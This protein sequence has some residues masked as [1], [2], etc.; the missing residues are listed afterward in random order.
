MILSTVRGRGAL[1]TPESEFESH[2]ECCALCLL[3]FLSL[4]SV[5]SL[6]FCQGLISHE[7]H[8]ACHCCPSWCGAMLWVHL[9][10]ARVPPGAAMGALSA[11][12]FSPRNRNPG[13]GIGDEEDP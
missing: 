12:P 7:P 6:G 13:H 4:V 3:F 2:R 5:L 8:G 10:G 11:L 9:Q 1:C